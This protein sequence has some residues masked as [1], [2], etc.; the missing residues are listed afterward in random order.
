MIIELESETDFRGWRIAAREACRRDISPDDMIWQTPDTVQD[1]FA[2]G[3]GTG[4]LKQNREDD[5]K[6]VVPRQ[7]LTKAERVI[8]LSDPQR[9]SRLY[10]LLWRYQ[11]HRTL[12]ETI[13]DPD[14]CWLNEGEKAIRRD[15]H[16]MHAFVR[17]RMAG[18]RSDGREQFAAWFEPTYRIE[19]LAAPFFQKRFANMDWVIVTPNAT[20]SWN[21][22]TLQTSAGGRREDV[23]SDDEQEDHWRTYFAAIFNPARLKLGAMRSEMPKKYWQN[24][25]ETRLIPELVRRSQAQANAMVEHGPTLPSKTARALSARTTDVA[26]PAVQISSLND[27]KA[28]CSSCT[29]CDLSACAS[30]SVFG[31]GPDTA[32]LMIVGEQPG[33]REDIAGR[34]F[35]GPAGDLLNACLSEAGLDR[36]DIYV[37][38]AVKHFRFTP[39]G[40]RRLH[41]SPSVGH[42]DACRWWLVQERR[43]VQPEIIVTLGA[44]ALRSV[45]EKPVELQTYRNQLIELEDGTQLIASVHP[46]YLLRLAQFEGAH[47]EKAQFIRD[48]VTA[49]TLLESDHAAMS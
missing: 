24:M 26:Q 45:L 37:T 22:A 29:D 36:K 19:M 49:K 27:L 46:A 48:L 10:R 35:V 11:T 6:I 14:V 43:F 16:K 9:F 21:G 33:D 32:R 40:K 13:T 20:I 44:T 2:A 25:P 17:F 18:T 23:P 7:F 4:T 31:E 28:A 12:F 34:P 38:N 41:K 15:I 1:L 5:R 8:C 47:Q 39:R 3:S 30:Q 42:I